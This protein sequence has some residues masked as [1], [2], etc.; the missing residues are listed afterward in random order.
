MT[1]PMSLTRRRFLTTAAS[2]ALPLAVPR[3][4]GSAVAAPLP[5]VKEEDV[6]ISF[7]LTGPVADE[8]WNAKHDQGVKAIKAA[9]PKAKTLVVESVPFSADASRTFRQFVQ[10]GSQMVFSTSNYGDF[11]TSVVERSPETAFLQADGRLVA[12]NLGWYYVKHWYPTYVLGV[13][14]GLLSKSGKL[15]FVAS[16]PVPVVFGATNAFLLGAR[17]VNPAAT[18]QVIA[19]NSWFDPQGANQAASALIDSGCDFLFG[20]MNE[21]AYLQVCEQRGV[22]AAMWNA[23]MRRFGENAYVSA[24]VPDWTAYYVDQVRQ[25]IEGRWQPGQTLL[26]MG[27]GVDRDAWGKAVPADVAAQ[28]D[29]VREKILGGWNPFAGE[30]KDSSGAVRVKSGEALDDL[31][32]YNW[33][34]AVEGVSGLSA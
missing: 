23:D 27:K 19:V 1:S 13:A 7:A 17:S 29:A 24:I 34:W 10:A 26:D 8:G 2:V 11:L 33:D 18:L 16:F 12:D 25:R 9:F 20:M 15:G 6:V 31:A 21:P 22:R 5:A 14:A 30:I 28:A 3:W 32:L 4:I